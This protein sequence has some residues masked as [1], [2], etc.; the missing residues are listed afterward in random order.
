MAC[1]SIRTKSSPF[2]GS[3]QPTSSTSLLARTSTLSSPAV[4][5]HNPARSAAAAESGPP[6]GSSLLSF[7][8]SFLT[9]AALVSPPY[10]NY[11]SRCTQHMKRLASREQVKRR[12]C[13]AQ[14]ATSRRSGL[15]PRWLSCTP[16]TPLLCS[17]QRCGWP[18]TSGPR[19]TA[20][21]VQ[22][23]NLPCDCS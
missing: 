9:R 16:H 14:R 15:G 8:R 6:P 10:W 19:R 4:P 7:C 18:V 17:S 2:Q 1:L 22:Q 20:S 5:P 11:F 3:S 12:Y 13:P 23:Q 21:A